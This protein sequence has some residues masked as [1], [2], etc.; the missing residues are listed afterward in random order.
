MTNQYTVR[1]YEVPKGARARPV[2]QPGFNIQ[3]RTI[4]KAEK[5][6]RTRLKSTDGRV[7]QALNHGPERVIHVY[8][9][10]PRR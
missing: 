6:V 7:I 10:A 9:S 4:P 3:A 5:A 1:L 8:L 2:A